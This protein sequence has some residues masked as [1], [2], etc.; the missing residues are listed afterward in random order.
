MWDTG[1]LLE[2]CFAKIVLP[3]CSLG[4][5]SP[6]N[7]QR[8][9]CKAGGGAGALWLT[10]FPLCLPPAHALDPFPPPSRVPQPNAALTPQLF[11]LPLTQV[12]VVCPT[13]S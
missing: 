9:L 5:H 2:V 6:F 12:Y 10:I 11:Q 1:P 3:A 8:V 7:T 4:F 13:D